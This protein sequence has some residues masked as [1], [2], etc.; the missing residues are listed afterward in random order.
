MSASTR[1]EKV[2]E[3]KLPQV[4]TVDG[5]GEVDEDEKEEA[6]GE[7]GKELTA[8]QKK[9]KKKREAQK[10]KKQQLKLDPES[11]LNASFASLSMH[12]VFHGPLKLACNKEFG[13]HVVA[14]V[15]IPAGAIVLEQEPYS[16][17]V[18]DR[19]I[20]SVCHRCFAKIDK[21]VIV[22]AECKQARYCSKACMKGAQN[23]HGLECKSLSKYVHRIIYA[24]TAPTSCSVHVRTT[25][26]RHNVTNPWP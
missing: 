1:S 15:D 8:A 16:A 5:V 25:S 11:D 24:A 12:N 13:R 4:G 20:D 26:T 14:A 18:V 3:D 2:A 23:V 10:R 9:N 22:C 21:L 6:E 19:V 7:E 17:V